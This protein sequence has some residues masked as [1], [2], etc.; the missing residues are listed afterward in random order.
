MLI[1]LFNGVL[2]GVT[3][4]IIQRLRIMNDRKTFRGGGREGG[5]DRGRGEWGGENGVGEGKGNAW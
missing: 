5:R 2:D 4:A 3:R 1:Y